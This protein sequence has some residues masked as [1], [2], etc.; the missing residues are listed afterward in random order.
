MRAAE[1]SA[2]PVRVAVDAERT[3]R[4]GYPT[5]GQLMDLLET[6]GI[7]G[8]PAGAGAREVLVTP[9]ALDG[10]LAG[11]GAAPGQPSA[12]RPG[13]R[14]ALTR[15]GPRRPVRLPGTSGTAGGG[16]SAGRGDLH[17]ARQRRPTMRC[18]APGRFPAGVAAGAAWTWSVAAPMN[19]D[20][21]PNP[22]ELSTAQVRALLDTGGAVPAPRPP[23][24]PG[25]HR[26]PVV[27]RPACLRRTGREQARGGPARGDRHRGEQPRSEQA[28]SVV[29]A[30]AADQPPRTT[31][32]ALASP[33]PRPGRGRHAVRAGAG[34]PVPR[35]PVPGQQPGPPQ[36]GPPRPGAR[37]WPTSVGRV[38]GAVLWDPR[39]V[40]E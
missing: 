6:G 34:A 7:V 2:Q 5:A 14:P 8:P 4:V 24:C 15:T 28:R 38:L 16:R 9:D 37:P 20:A 19:P 3:M 12:Q 33:R 18:A 39:R 25:P 29:C 32:S 13:C 35:A 1:W 11:L 22:A 21:A 36:P 31:A 30:G 27:A 17:P 23:A 26:N 10:V 40:R